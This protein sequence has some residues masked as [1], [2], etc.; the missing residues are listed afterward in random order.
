MSERD[1]L[2]STDAGTVQ[3]NRMAI[4]NFKSLVG[5][6]MSLTKF[7][8]LIG[9]NGAGKSTILQAM[10][11]LSQQMRGDLAG[12][13][14]SR[15]WKAI[16]LKSK[17][18]KS[19]NITFELE[20]DLQGESLVWRG[21]F[22]RTLLR[23]TQ[24]SI[25]I[26]GVLVMKVDDGRFLVERD[27]EGDPLTGDIAFEY[28][29]SV[30]SRL[31]EE[32]VSGRLLVFKHFIA[33]ITSLDALSPQHLR[34]KSRETDG[35]LGF[36]GEKF[37]SFL[38]ALP[39]AH[40]LK[41][42]ELL[43]GP[44]PQVQGIDLSALRAGWKSLSILERYA[45]HRFSTE[46]RHMN[47]G[48]LRLMAIIAETL[49]DHQFMLF[50]EVENGIHPEVIEFLLDHLVSTPQQV[51]VT[52]HS[53][54]VLNYLEDDIARGGVQLIYKTHEGKTRAV[55]FFNIPAMAEK[56]T[57]MGPGEVFVDTNL[58]ALNQDLVR[59]NGGA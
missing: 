52:T 20:C 24:E 2:K 1:P 4:D 21:S 38:H 49:S 57:V 40:K 10:D 35:G 59:T 28:Q 34:R 56:L 9:L 22:N 53:P 6:T 19:S 25:E 58:V 41:L 46:A 5:F 26:D 18:S 37:S 54:M 29:G 30:L 8:C 7:T 55:S 16:D 31:R 42:R 48:M 12:W 13:L 27:E 11:F 14:K 36:A 39:D 50:D 43:S 3:L 32:S 47:D 23:C 51:M 33:T 17:L 45:D 44:Y 15:E